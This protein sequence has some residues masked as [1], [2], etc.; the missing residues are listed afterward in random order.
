MDTTNKIALVGGGVGFLKFLEVMGADFE[1]TTLSA[2]LRDERYRGM[3]LLP[4]YDGGEDFVDEMSLSDMELLARRKTEGFRVYSENY[5][6]LN[7]YSDSVFAFSVQGSVCRTNNQS[8]CAMG[9][10]QYI[11]GGERI[12]Q[13]SDVRY[14][15]GCESFA[16]SG[17]LVKEI[18]LS[19]GGYYGTSQ[20]K[21]LDVKDSM[22]VLIR[23]GSFL[24]AAMSFTEFDSVNMRPNCRFKKLFGYI[25]SFVTGIPRERVE[26][27]FEACYPPIKTRFDVNAVL[28]ED[29]KRELY[30]KALYDAV[31]WHFTSGMILGEH[32]EDGAVEMVLSNNAQRNR[33]NR[34]VDSGM[35][36][37]WLLYA[38]GKYFKNDDWKLTG[39]N[40]FDYFLTHAQLSGGVVDGMFDWFYNK[41]STPKDIYSIDLGRDGI[42]LCNMYR[43]CGEKK[44]L[45][46]VKRLAESVFGWI[47][48][49]RLYNV[50]IPYGKIGTEKHVKTDGT[51]T[52]AIYG[53]LSSFMAMAS[54]ITGDSKY[55]ERMVPVCDML[56][57]IYP[58][59]DY[60]GHT[61][62][63]RIAR[64]LMT[65]LPV[66]LSG[67]R[68]YSE[69]INEAIDY[70]DSLRT[71]QGGIY[72]EDNITFEKML[73][74]NGECGITT[75]WDNDRISDQLY[76][77]NNA[78]AAL[79]IICELPDG[80]AVNK[81]KG[82]RLY[83]SLL[84]YIVKIQIVSDDGRFMGGWMRAYCM[85]L[86]EYYGL[87]ADSLWSSYC[88]MAGWTMGILP[89]SLLSA[90][91]GLCPYV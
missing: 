89:L 57:K 78:L 25:F 27:A 85:N 60:Y 86:G 66:Q 68:D 19:M 15:P 67:R 53:E 17:V 30:E 7:S 18:L 52:P 24:T 10:L 90:L 35:Y 9:G 13:A 32:G 73:K 16:D 79:S 23:S 58:D 11:L 84:D 47:D 40:V 43:L 3:L 31:R 50:F 51:C 75:P 12:L 87:D 39:K 22:P 88:I 42:A 21:T 91:E 70:L 59:Y 69:I 55:I 83:K 34:R 77:V 76:C 6:S 1:K 45:D 72:S 80:T 20:V 2:A 61:T 14:F 49:D 62:S 54:R 5:L 38:A 44:I 65:L 71:S 41:Y 26:S 64:L 28:P 4:D 56:V 81:E 33:N 48:G 8:L 74:R 36:T 46:A 63:S 37:G 29:R 82:L